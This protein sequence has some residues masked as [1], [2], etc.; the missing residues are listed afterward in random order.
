MTPA[1]MDL[2]T[3]DFPTKTIYPATLPVAEAAESFIITLA[4]LMIDKKRLLDLLASLKYTVEDSLLILHPFAI[5]PQEL[6]HTKLGFSMDRTAL[7]LG[8]YL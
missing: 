6:I 5:G 3:E 1:Q 2:T 7:N 4:S 8:T